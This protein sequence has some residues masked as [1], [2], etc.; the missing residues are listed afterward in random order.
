MA[1]MPARTKYRKQQRGI[2]K[3]T[4]HRGNGVAFGEF[5]LQSL[6]PGYVTGR[7]IEAC[8]VT[9]SRA[10]GAAGKYW[11][12][13]FP[14][15]PMSAHPLESRMGHGKGEPDHWVAVIHPGTVMFE[16]GNIPEPLARLALNKAASKLPL[17]C[18]LAAKR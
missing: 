7:Q 8:R 11:I 18:R 13:I 15:K 2:V 16:V 4:A 5:G 3:G 12:R 17:R 10:V 6:E 1:L 14:H 9:I